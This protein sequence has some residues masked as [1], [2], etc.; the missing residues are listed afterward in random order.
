MTGKPNT[1]LP[2]ID[3]VL[4]HRGTMQLLDAVTAFSPESATARYRVDATAWYA[5]ADGAMPAWIGI[6]LMAQAVAAHVALL[7]RSKG[8]P[9][10]AGA[11]LGTRSFQSLRP[12]FPAET[13]LTITAHLEFRDDSGLGAYEC[14]I[15]LG[16]EVAATSTLKVFEPE[17]FGQFIAG[18]KETS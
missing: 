4:L 3:E 7:A 16:D 1:A 2:P 18:G 13:E 12:A 17:D 9:P 10:R 8:L 14:E 11:L 6:E 15:A 5:D